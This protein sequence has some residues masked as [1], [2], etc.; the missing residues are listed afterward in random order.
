MA[1]PLR[2]EYPGA[3]YHVMSRGIERRVIVRD[4]HDRERRLDWLRRTVETY[5]WRLH[6]FALMPNHDHLFVETPDANLSTGMQFFNGSYV[7]YF[8]FRHKRAG[9]LFQGRFKAQ[10]IE[11]EGHYLEI[12]RY[13]HLNPVRAKL[14]DRPQAYPWSS[15]PGYVRRTRAA[16]WITY[17][18]VLAEFGSEDAS[19]RRRYRQFVLAGI[20][21][22]LRSPF[23][24]AV[25]N[26]IVGSDD[27]VEKV[28]MML[29]DRQ[30]SAGLPALNRLRI[31][32]SLEHII[33]VVATCTKE[34]RANWSSGR[35]C[36]DTGRALAAYVARARFGYSASAVAR[37]LGYAGPSAVT[38]VLKR[39]RPSHAKTI[40]RIER[41]LA[42]HYSSSDP[43]RRLI[44][45]ERA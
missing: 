34:T 7:S 25:H 14:V 5:G 41:D 11:R 3:L 1:R 35:R 15:F 16:N 4:D 30:A 31:R 28:K 27:F 19:A 17:D 37:A 36:D 42:I 6:A 21:P 40:R 8:N 45:A 20:D 23:A 10:L 32:P 22:P 38:H 2:I 33:A 29:A 18:H 9:H 24:D 12:S 13:I 39:L 43:I 26:I 44:S